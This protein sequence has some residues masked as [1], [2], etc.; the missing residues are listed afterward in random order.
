MA[1]G[2]DMV[3]EHGNQCKREIVRV[4]GITNSSCFHNG[5]NEL[6]TISKIH[7]LVTNN[8]PHQD[9]VIKVAS[10]RLDCVLIAVK[11]QS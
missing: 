7:A 10:V 4:V 8:L 9:L 1:Q 6:E 5:I 3:V 2:W 11:S